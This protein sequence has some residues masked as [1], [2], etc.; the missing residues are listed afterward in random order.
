MYAPVPNGLAPNPFDARQFVDRA[1]GMGAAVGQDIAYARR[2]DAR[3]QA[4][5]V[6]RC[7]VQVHHAFKLDLLRPRQRNE[8]REHPYGNKKRSH[9][10]FFSAMGRKKLRASVP[11]NS[12]C[13]LWFN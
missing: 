2:P 11:P 13:S 1:K 7:G 4:Q 12:R 3:N 6:G 9:H 8:R 5:F 10:A